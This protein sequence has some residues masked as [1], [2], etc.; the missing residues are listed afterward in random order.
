M[1]YVDPY[2]ARSVSLAEWVPDSTLLG[3]QEALILQWTV[4]EKEDTF[5]KSVLQR[6]ENR[7][8]NPDE[9]G[10]ETMNNWCNKR[11]LM[12]VVVLLFFF[13]MHCVVE[14]SLLKFKL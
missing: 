8:M 1:F 6:A 2:N 9:S 10:F 5:S 11:L 7:R 13:T 14:S 3:G 4:K 12:F